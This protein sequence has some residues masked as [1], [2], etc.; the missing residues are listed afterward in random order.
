MVY[1][2]VMK[3]RMRMMK[4]MILLLLAEKEV[5]PLSDCVH[6]NISRGV[7][8]ISDRRNCAS[9]ISPVLL[10]DWVEVLP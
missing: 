5:S 10:I 4:E 3:T 9:C 6:S 8:D 2:P 7:N 1:V